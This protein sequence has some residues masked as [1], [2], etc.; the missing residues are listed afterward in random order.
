MPLSL[1]LKTDENGSYE[2][3]EVSFIVWHSNML[4]KLVLFPGVAEQSTNLQ[5]ISRSW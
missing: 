2:I 5:W 3:S 1:L 4:N